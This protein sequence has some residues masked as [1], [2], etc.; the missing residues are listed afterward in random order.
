MAYTSICVLAI[1]VLHSIVQLL[2]LQLKENEELQINVTIRNEEKERMETQLN[3][4]RE[5]LSEMV[6]TI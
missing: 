3:E 2:L 5:Q 6:S 4:L 1:Y